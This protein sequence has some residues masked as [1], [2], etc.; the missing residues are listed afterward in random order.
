MKAL[1]TGATGFIGSG[2]SGICWRG[3]SGK[4]AG[5]SGEK[6][7]I[8]ETGSKNRPGGPDGSEKPTWH[9][10]RYRYGVSPGGTRYGLGNKAAVL[11]SHL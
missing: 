2:L 7:E 3:P 10:Q 8:R 5:A 4:S 11:Y 6:A 1:V 9:L